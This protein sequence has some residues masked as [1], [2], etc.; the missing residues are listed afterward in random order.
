MERVIRYE[1]E[2][3]LPDELSRLLEDV[4]E[5]VIEDRNETD[6]VLVHFSWLKHRI[7]GWLL[8]HELECRLSRF[9]GSREIR[10]V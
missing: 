4:Q 8:N 5:Y 3:V 10:E 6:K 7:I 1:S 2:T 9:S